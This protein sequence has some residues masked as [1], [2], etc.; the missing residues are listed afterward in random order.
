MTKCKGDA[1][2]RKEHQIIS[3]GLG[4]GTRLMRHSQISMRYRD[5][6][7]K[8]AKMIEIDVWLKWDF[9]KNVKNYRHIA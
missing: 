4:L 1:G 9:C 2:L 7:S 5:E 8:L 3:E 6:G